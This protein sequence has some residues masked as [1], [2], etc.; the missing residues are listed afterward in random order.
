[1]FPLRKLVK[2]VDLF[3]N[4]QKAYNVIPIGSTHIPIRSKI[5]FFDYFLLGENK[6]E[7]EVSSGQLMTLFIPIDPTYILA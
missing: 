4:Y 1:M 2:K 6:E 5:I 3:F 7:E